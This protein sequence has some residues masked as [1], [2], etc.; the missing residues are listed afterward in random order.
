MGLGHGPV[1]TPARAHFTPMKNELLL[2]GTE[3][4]HISK[5]SVYSENNIV[6][7]F[8]NMNFMGTT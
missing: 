6:A 8:V 7:V 1:N 4:I 2:D 3:F 5:I